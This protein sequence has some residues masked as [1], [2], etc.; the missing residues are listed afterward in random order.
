MT[1]KNLLKL[2]ICAILF[3]C[4]S[5]DE[6]ENNVINLPASI[7]VNVSSL[8]F[9]NTMVNQVSE[10]QVIIINVENTT[11]EVNISVPEGYEVSLDNNS[12]SQSHTFV[13]EVSNEV[14]IRFTPAEAINYYSTLTI[15]SNDISNNININ[16]FGLGTPLIH[17]YQAFQNQA[18]GYGGGFSQSASQIFTLH[19]D[20]S[21]I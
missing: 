5:D 4:S 6:S 20:L 13:P 16:L 10:S 17:N 7:S 21:E 9:E 18:L 8:S 3:T 11:S 2:L 1:M 19:N 12:F 15:S 14:Y